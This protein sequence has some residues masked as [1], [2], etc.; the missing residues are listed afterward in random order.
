MEIPSEPGRDLDA[1][2]G[3]KV[4]GLPGVGYYK[5]KSCYTHEWAPCVKGDPTDDYPGWVATAPYYLPGADTMGVDGALMLSSFGPRAIP[6]YSVDISHA[7]QVLQHVACK[8]HWRFCIGSQ[9]GYDSGPLYWVTIMH[10][11]KQWEGDSRYGDM[12]DSL[13]LA[14][15]RACLLTVEGLKTKEPLE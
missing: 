2:I 15:C 9:E 10:G 6:Q 4:M 14:I 13:P 12:E 5:R 3:Q 8:K 7:W 1:I 11:G